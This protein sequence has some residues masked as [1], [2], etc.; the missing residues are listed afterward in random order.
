MKI[1]RVFKTLSLL[2][3]ILYA[4]FRLALIIMPDT[5]KPDERYLV[6]PIMEI[7]DDKN[8]FTLLKK[9]TTTEEHFFY[10]GF[11][12]T[13]IVESDPE[14]YN[15]FIEKYKEDI[16][17]LERA[18]EMPY[19][20]YRPAEDL[21]EGKLAIAQYV[22]LM[23]L[24]LG[25]AWHEN[26][27]GNSKE[28]LKIISTLLKMCNLMLMPENSDFT[29][30]V[31]RLYYRKTCILINAIVS[32][33]DISSDDLKLLIATLDKYKMRYDG[34]K[35]ALAE[36]YY[37]ITYLLYNNEQFT[38]KSFLARLGLSS[39]LKPDRSS[40]YLSEAFSFYIKNIDSP[41]CSIDFPSTSWSERLSINSSTE[42]FRGNQFGDLLV[43]INL[44]R[45]CDILNGW[46]LNFFETEYISNALL[47]KLAILL[48][49]N[50]NGKSP[51]SL[52]EL[53]PDYIKSVPDDPFV[54]KPIHYDSERKILY[55]VGHNCI[56]DG[57]SAEKFI[58]NSLE[59][60]SLKEEPDYVVL[61]H[62]N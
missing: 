20:A 29:V 8:A 34:A 16:E 26:K 2:A 19:M 42:Y 9:Y 31:G 23:D 27:K 47:T 32:D 28:A 56:D 40:S 41:Y 46:T 45:Y 11:K 14:V 50:E 21:L 3:F 57:G 48:Y 24:L 7:P 10:D 39:G 38:E 53:V 54:R 13:N 58:N 22:T 60:E 12:S 37:S 4:L 25:K 52:D 51:D 61:I 59:Y 33:S 17:I 5:P 44:Y 43:R 49:E 55:S 36:Q 18:S 1:L 62:P 30:L 6:T 35:W 15:T